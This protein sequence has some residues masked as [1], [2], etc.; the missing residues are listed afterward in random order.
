MYIVGAS[1]K[2]D[3]NIPLAELISKQTAAQTEVVQKELEAAIAANDTSG[4]ATLRQTL[5][6]IAAAQKRVETNPKRLLG[7]ED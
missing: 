4:A 1:N 5:K 7:I 2:S 6:A 3:M